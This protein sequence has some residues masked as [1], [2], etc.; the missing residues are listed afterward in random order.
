LE[1]EAVTFQQERKELKEQCTDMESSLDLLREEYE[2]C[3]DYWHDKLQEA[4]DIYEQ[5]KHAMDEKFQDLLIK[6]NEYEETF[7]STNATNYP[8]KLPPIEE[9]ASLEQQVTDLEEE[10]D[11]LRRELYSLKE[12]QDSVLTTYQRELEVNSMHFFSS[13]IYYKNVELYFLYSHGQ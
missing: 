7:M 8:M 13:I 3:E 11:E 12:E 6:I 2:K 10:C 5:D 1:N 9:R 4:S